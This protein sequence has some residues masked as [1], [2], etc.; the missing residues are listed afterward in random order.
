[1]LG[2]KLQNNYIITHFKIKIIC[3]K[4][5]KNQWLNKKFSNK[6]LVINTMVSSTTHHCYQNWLENKSMINFSEEP[7]GQ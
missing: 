4:F 1:M 6:K 7:Y 5:H 2:K 3:V